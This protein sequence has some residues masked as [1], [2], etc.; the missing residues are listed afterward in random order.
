MYLSNEKVKELVRKLFNYLKLIF[1]GMR[2]R[3]YKVTQNVWVYMRL[4]RAFHRT[5]L[6]EF[7][8]ST[9]TMNLNI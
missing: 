9:V 7:F 1:R 6:I 4:L 8:R 2:E 3:S 5:F